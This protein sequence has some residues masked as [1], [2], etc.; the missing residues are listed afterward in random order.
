MAWNF[1]SKQLRQQH[2]LFVV[3]EAMSA[4]IETKPQ[5][6]EDESPSSLIGSVTFSKN[7][8]QISSSVSM[9]DILWIQS[10]V[11]K[12]SKIKQTYFQMFKGIRLKD[13]I[14]K[15]KW[16]FEQKKEDNKTNR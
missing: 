11:E 5:N 14:Y 4:T 3:D 6:A 15:R 8:S 16:T 9:F 1:F 2:V 12:Q 7:I 10:D 13:E